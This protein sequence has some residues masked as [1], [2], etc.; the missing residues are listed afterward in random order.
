MQQRASHQNDP[1]EPRTKTEQD[2]IGREA[3]LRH[4]RRINQ[5]ND[6]QMASDHWAANRSGLTAVRKT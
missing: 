2:N 3:R 6:Q 4:K 1:G 5:A